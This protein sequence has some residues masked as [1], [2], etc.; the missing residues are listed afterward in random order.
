MGNGSFPISSFPSLIL[1]RI[2]FAQNNH[3]GSP[4]NVVSRDGSAC[5]RACVYIY[6]E[7]ERRTHAYVL[8]IELSE[9]YTF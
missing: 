9:E 7:R 1:F 2:D 3:L 6:I 4:Y 8:Y 5:V